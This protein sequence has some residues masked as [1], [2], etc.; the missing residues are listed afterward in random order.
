MKIKFDHYVKVD[1]K[2]TFGYKWVKSNE[3][4]RHLYLGQSGKGYCVGITYN[5]DER[6]AFKD[7]SGY[8]KSCNEENNLPTGKEGTYKM[9][10]ASILILLDRYPQTKLLSWQDNTM[11]TIN[12]QYDISLSDSDTI[13]YGKPR[14]ISVVG[15]KSVKQKFYVPYAADILRKLENKQYNF[16]TFWEKYFKQ[17]KLFSK[18]EYETL[19]IIYNNSKTLIDFFQKADQ[20]LSNNFKKKWI[21]ISL[22]NI[23]QAHNIQSFVGQ[24]WVIDLTEAVKHIDIKLETTNKGYTKIL[25]TGGGTVLDNFQVELPKTRIR[26]V[27]GPSGDILYINSKYYF[28]N[29][30]RQYIK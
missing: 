19:H 1:N 20:F 7:N 17:F 25:Y 5:K 15:E 30:L 28:L 29:S 10:F 9:I 6:M 24:N 14:I 16:D 26:H 8:F 2:Y 12:N 3:T 27:D 22:S 21:F 18:N 4:E 23:F 13:L 11:V